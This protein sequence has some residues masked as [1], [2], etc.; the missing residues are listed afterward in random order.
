MIQHPN[1]DEQRVI[2]LAHFANR[3]VMKI[4]VQTDGVLHAVLVDLL[5]E[6][7]VPVKQAYRDKIEVEIAGRFAVVAGE[8]AEAAR[9]VRDR[10]VKT[11]LGGE[12]S[13][14][15]VQGGAGAGFAVGVFPRQIFFKSV[16]DFLDFAQKRF[17][18]RQ[19]FQARLPRKLQHARR[20]VIGPIP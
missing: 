19:F 9:V 15:F 2:A 3:E 6:I 17:V 10:F 7:A 16:V 1:R 18:L 13:D 11:K 5:P 8:D 14:R 20:V 12:I 4:L